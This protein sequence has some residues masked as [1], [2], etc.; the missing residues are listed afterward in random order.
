MRLYTQMIRLAV[1][2]GLLSAAAVCGGW[3]WEGLPL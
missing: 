2:A 1:L 3:K